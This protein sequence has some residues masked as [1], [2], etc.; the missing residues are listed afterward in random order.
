MQALRRVWVQQYTRGQDGTVTRRERPESGLRP[1]RSRISSPYD[2]MSA[3][4]ETRQD[5]HG[6]RSTH[7]DLPHP[8]DR[9]SLNLITNVAT[10]VAAVPDAR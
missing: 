1:G 7:R 2:R 4:A 3:T 9:R 8:A 10:T 6:Y 5:W